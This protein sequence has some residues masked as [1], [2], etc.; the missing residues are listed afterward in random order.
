MSLEQAAVAMNGTLAG[1]DLNFVGVSTD[2]RNLQPGELF[3]ALKGEN[4]DGHD[5]CREAAE[6]GAAAA[7]VDKDIEQCLATVR[8]VD[9]RFA[10]GD[11]AKSWRSEH[12]VR[13]VGVTGSNGKTT[14]K[15]MVASILNQQGSVLS[16]T[17]NFNNEIGLPKTLFALQD[18]HEYAVIEMGANHIGEISR[19]ASI[20]KPDVAIITLCAPAHLE[21]FGSIEGVAQAKGEIYESLPDQGVAI[22]NADDKFKPYWERIIGDR[23]VI[24]FG[25]DSVHANVTATNIRPQGLGEGTQFNLHYQGRVTAVRI[26]HDGS[27]NVMNA[28]A[29]SA[30]GIALGCDES[31]IGRGLAGSGIAAG[32]LNI[33]Q[34][35]QRVKLIDDTYNA[36]P[37][38]LLAASRVAAMGSGKTWVV[39]GDMAE[40]GEDGEILHAQCA[41]EMRA[42]GINKLFTVGELAAAAAEAFGENAASFDSKDH[43]LSAVLGELNADTNS[44]FTILVKGSR[45]M[46]METLVRALQESS[47]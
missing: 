37:T 46:K 38:S 3:F 12:K 16:T 36:N 25:M 30:A 35:G 44:S 6:L 1:A 21:G 28:L 40:L 24:T 13:V 8:V 10:L 4:F 22:L 27:H 43:L 9:T 31:V 42:I 5:L 29:A 32:R 18:T 41:R 15:E 45:A 19:L 47:L 33:S 14:V 17:G 39:L 26:P 23:N 20:A 34:L 7:V 11:L 2:T